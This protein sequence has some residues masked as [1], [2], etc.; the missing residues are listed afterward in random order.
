M[1]ASAVRKILQRDRHAAAQ[2]GQN[3]Q[4]KRN[5]GG[6]RYGPAPHGLGIAHVEQ[7]VDC[8]RCGHTADGGCTRQDDLIAR[9]KV[10]L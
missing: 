6:G 7:D 1:M 9:G 2:Q 3:T 4:G 5:I 10:A 8:R